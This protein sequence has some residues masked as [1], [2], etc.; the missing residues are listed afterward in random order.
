MI[1]VERL[2][3][4]LAAVEAA[5]LVGG[6]DQRFWRGQADGGCGTAMCFAGWVCQI[7]GGRWLEDACAT[8]GDRLVPEADD[9]PRDMYG[10][11]G[12][13]AGDRAQRLLG[14]NHEQADVLFAPENDLDD[15]RDQVAYLIEQAEQEAARL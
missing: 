4:G 11:D 2:R 12:I 5:A 15:L 3:A 13:M 1:N 7:N 9:D 14:L 8:N 10:P 6:W